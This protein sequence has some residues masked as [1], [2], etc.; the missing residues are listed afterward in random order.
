M[1]DYDALVRC[2][3]LLR[4]SVHGNAGDVMLPPICQTVRLTINIIQVGL[5]EI[6][7]HRGRGLRLIV[8][9]TGDACSVSHGSW[10]K[11]EC[12]W[13]GSRPGCIS[14]H[15]RAQYFAGHRSEAPKSSIW[16]RECQYAFIGGLT[17]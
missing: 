7:S 16:P 3:V 5:L 9:S 17:G 12:C 11:L 6:W 14:S 10:R 4:A 15:F 2:F 1:T 13:K 8:D